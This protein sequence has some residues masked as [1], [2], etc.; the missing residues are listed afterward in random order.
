[1]V[2]II[3]LQA[4]N[5]K[6]VRLVALSPTYWTTSAVSFLFGFIINPR[7]D[8]F[9]DSDDATTK[10]SHFGLILCLEVAI[11]YSEE[12]LFNY[13]QIQN[14]QILPPLIIIISTCHYR[15]SVVP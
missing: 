13:S 8:S 6:G 15:S 11:V 7:A 12:T 10:P 5:E 3:M 4:K 1:M 9:L 14:S 2:L